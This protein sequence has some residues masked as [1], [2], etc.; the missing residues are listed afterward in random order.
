MR[1][2]FECFVVMVMLAGSAIATP[3]S[4]LEAHFVHPGG[5]FKQSDLDRMR[6]QVQAKIDPWYASFQEMQKEERA[7]YDYEVRGHEFTEVERGGA[8]GGAFESDANAAYLNALM[9]AITQDKR[10]AG[11]CVEIFN[12]WK[13]L[14][15]VSGN[16]TAPLNAGLLVWKMVEAAEIIKSTYPGWQAGDMK[17][18]QEM[19]V[20]PRYSDSSVPSA[21]DRE[22]GGFY[23]RIYNGDPG[24]HGNQ[25]MMAYRGMITMGV[26][27][28][29]QTMYDR[30]LR[31]FKGDPG[32]RDD[33]EMP[34]GP[35]IVGDEKSDNEYVT[36]YEVEGR[37]SS[38][39]NYGYNGVLTN[40]FWENGQCQE[41][42]RDQQ[43]AF[44]GLSIAQGIAEVAWNQGDPVWNAFDSRLLK[45]F[46][47]ASKY[48]TSYIASFPDQPEPWEPTGNEFIQRKDRTGRWYSKKINPYYESDFE[49]VSRGEFPGKRPIYEQAVAHFGVRMGMSTNDY[50]W[51][52]RGRDVSILEYGFEKN[53]FSLDHAG[54]GALCFRRPARA[55]GD[56]VC[57]FSESGIPQFGIHVLPGKIEAENYDWFPGGGEG[58]TFHDGTK[59]NAGNIYRQDGVDIDNR[60]A[61]GPYLINLEA[62][63]WL[64]Y[65]VFVPQDGRYGV[66]VRYRGVAGGAL[67]CAFG[68]ELVSDPVGL[69]TSGKGAEWSMQTLAEN[70]ELKAGVQVMR[71]LVEGQPER[72]HLDTIKIFEEQ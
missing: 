36:T 39:D 42:S 27:L 4:D 35:P 58:R 44:F 54:W 43:H 66:R 6:F 2:R 71:I 60:M 25:D 15:H 47:F 45:A 40:Y 37:K 46:E 3:A 5:L 69:P 65:T 51:T 1:V 12:A 11:K 62:G 48:N 61:E 55:A 23:W 13:D 18:F 17:D 63:E 19:L 64:S 29:N 67:R 33:I 49:K 34:A 41:S 24:R 10:H 53:G 30:A 16:G 7:G 28:D 70:L 21:V 22:K 14:T 52:L 31:Y 26:F 8:N 57:G 38:E 56:P 68:D 20:Y 59:G 72:L 9:W 50:L 32:R